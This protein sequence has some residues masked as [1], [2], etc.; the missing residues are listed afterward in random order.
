MG[1]GFLIFICFLVVSISSL[2]A[3]E[4]KTSTNDTL[5]FKRSL[6]SLSLSDIYLKR[7]KIDFDFLFDE[8]GK[9]A[10]SVSYLRSFSENDFEVYHSNIQYWTSIGFKLFPMGQKRF[11]FYLGPEIMFI[12]TIQ[13]YF[14]AGGGDTKFYKHRDRLFLLLSL[15]TKYDI[16]KSIVFSVNLGLGFQGTSGLIGIE[17]LLIADVGLGFKF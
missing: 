1:R 11:S 10:F 2:N 6:I 14:V 12:S 9:V 13:Y 16:S 4:I 8:K 15:G 5:K 7:L 3:Q 17:G